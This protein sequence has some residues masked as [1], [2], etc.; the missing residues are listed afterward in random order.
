MEVDKGAEEVSCHHTKSCLIM[1]F[2]KKK[3]IMDKEILKNCAMM[4]ILRSALIFIMV[5]AVIEA[6]ISTKMDGENIVQL[7]TI[8]QYWEALWIIVILGIGIL[9]L[10]AIIFYCCFKGGETLGKIVLYW[11]VWS[12]CVGYT[13]FQKHMDVS[14]VIFLAIPGMTVFFYPRWGHT[15]TMEKYYHGWV[16]AFLGLV[17][18]YYSF[19]LIGNELFMQGKRMNINYITFSLFIIFTVA[20]YPSI[21]A[22][23]LFFEWLVKKV[24]KLEP[25]EDRKKIFLAGVIC[26]AITGL[27]LF[28]GAYGFYPAAMGHDSVSH[29]TQALGYYPIT[30]EHPIAFVILIRFLAC[31]YNN[32]FVFVIFQ[33]IFFSFVAG[34]FFSYLREKGIPLLF[35]VP[36]AAVLGVLPN[37]YTEVAY[38]SKNPL[39]SIINLWIII[40]LVKLFEHPEKCERILFRKKLLISF[41]ALYLVRHNNIPAFIAGAAALV[42]LTIKCYKV[43]KMHL[44]DIT[45]SA[46]VLIALIIGPVYAAVAQ[47]GKGSYLSLSYML[48]NGISAAL[49]SALANN[50][51]LPEETLEVMNR[52]LPLGMWEERFKPHNYD[53]FVWTEPRPDYTV[54]NGAEYLKAYGR[55]F[56]SDP[57]IVIKSWLDLNES[58]WNISMAKTSY[59]MRFTYGIPADMPQELLPKEI[60]G[61]DE[62]YKTITTPYALGFANWTANIKIL[63]ILIW[64]SGIYIVLLL[65]FIVFLAVNRHFNWIWVILPTC[66]TIGTYVVFL[67]WQTYSYTYFIGIG[68]VFF[69]IMTLLALFTKGEDFK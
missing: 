46:V 31:I 58:L 68:V 40:L 24:R 39:F 69:A 22:A 2:G 32:P 54:I 55:L 4:T 3:I 30:G 5:F 48:N 29:W 63:D 9:A 12:F 66:M 1:I 67:G 56:I 37:N 51:D 65:C 60:Q 19:A 14:T 6:S 18:V 47:P 62:P 16:K 57:D 34:S 17:S 49:E 35:L 11:F 26:G 50:V 52:V 7:F 21:Y 42:Y 25:E 23:M 27:L 13:L 59:N 8:G 28:C 15:L 10:T 33:I 43:V 38:F 45:V 41:V 20:L 64:R 36:F 44:I 61:L 53:V